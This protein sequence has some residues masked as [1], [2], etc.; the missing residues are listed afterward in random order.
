[1]VTIKII[2]ICIYLLFLHHH[3]HHPHHC[4]RHLSVCMCID[5]CCCSVAKSSLTLRRPLELQHVRFP[6]PSLSPRVCSNS[7]PLSWWCL[8]SISS[9]VTLFSFCLQSFPSLGSFPVSWLFSSVGQSHWS[10]SFSISPSNEYSGLFSF[11]IDW[12]D[13]LV[14][15]G[16]S[17][18]FSNTT[19]QK[20]QFFGAQP[21]LWYIHTWQLEKPYLWPYGSLLA[22]WCLCFLIHCLGL[23]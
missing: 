22:K 11:R 16:L 8:P 14:V 9:F 13:L 20:Y 7:C 4:H 23:S 5:I 12:F 6:C 21:S 19:V 17:R 3:H 10:F 18:V 15:Q 2:S 1:M